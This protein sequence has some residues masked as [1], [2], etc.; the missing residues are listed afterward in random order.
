M[1]PIA[2]AAIRA[3]PAPPRSTR[4]PLRPGG[5]SPPRTASPRAD[6]EQAAPPVAARVELHRLEPERF[7]ALPY[8]RQAIGE[9]RDPPRLHLDAGAITMVPDPQIPV[10]A[11]LAQERLGFLHL[12]Q[13]PRRDADAVLYPARQARCG[14]RVPNREAERPRRLP[15]GRLTHARLRQRRKHAGGDPRRVAG[16]MLTG[17]QVVRIGAVAHHGESSLTGDESQ[18]PPQLRLAVEAPVRRV[19]EIGGVL[20]LPGLH[21]EQRDPV[22]VGQRPGG[23]VLRL[24][25]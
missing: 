10:H 2:P 12:A 7:E 22:A 16:P 4:R 14:W 19:G 6:R 11:Q 8:P 1:P 25:I 20:E 24:W 9:E 3:G 17:C 15:H 5:G 21:F 18:P 23:L 13:S